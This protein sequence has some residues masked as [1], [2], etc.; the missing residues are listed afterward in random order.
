MVDPWDEAPI[1]AP[2]TAAPTL[3]QIVAPQR[4]APTGFR[5]NDAGDLEPIPG[6]PATK[7]DPPAGYRVSADGN[8]EFIPGGPADKTVTTDP[9]LQEAERTAA[10][11]ATRVLGGIK[12]IQAVTK[13]APSANK[14]GWIA[15]FAG[16]FGDE[17][18]NWANSPERRQ[19]EA[20][21][22][23]ILDAALT[24]GTGAAYTKEQLESYRQAYFPKLTDDK[25]TVEAKRTRLLRLLEAAKLKAGN[26]SPQID[27]A[28]KSLGGADQP[29]Q[30]LGPG[31]IGFNQAPAPENPLN[32]EQQA[33]YDAFNAANPKAT[34]AQLQAFGASIGVGIPNAE[35]IIEAR[36]KGAGVQPGSTAELGLTPEE[37]AQVDARVAGTS[38]AERIGAGMADTLT[39]GASDKIIAAG[40]GLAGNGDYDRELLMANAVTDQIADEHPWQYHGGQV[41]G[42]LI[43]PMF[44]ARTPAQLAK[45]GAAYGAAYGLGSSDTLAEVPGNVATGTVI[46]GGTG[47][48]GGKLVEKLGARSAAKAARPASESAER[49][50]RAAQFDID[51]P[52]GATSRTAAGVEKGLDILP[53]SAGRMQDARTALTGQ[54]ENAVETVASGHGPTTSFRGLGEA[55]QRGSNSWISKFEDVSSKAYDAIPISDKAAST[56]G[57]TRTALSEL[58]TI[59]ESNPK[60][61]EAFTN[62]RLNR[63]MEALDPANGGLSWKDLKAFRSRIG[64]EIGDQRFSESPT[65]TELRRLYGAL[66][67]DMRSTAMAQGP[68]ALRKFERANDLYRAGQ[69]RIEGA[70]TKILGDD[71]AKSPETAAARIQAL[72][73]EGKSSADL[74]LVHEVWKSLPAE[75]RGEVA[76]SLIRLA[77]QP[78]N[79]A[80]REFDPSVFVRSFK[81]MSPEAKNLIFG[82]VGKDLRTNL[83]EFV[84]VMGDLGANNALRNTSNTANAINMAGI[85]SVF[86]TAL[87]SF[88]VAAGIAGQTLGAYG[89]ARLW[90]NPK[91]VRWAT[92]YSK[93]LR[94]A[95]KAGTQPTKQGFVTQAKLLEKIAANDPGVAQDALGVRQMILS[96]VNENVPAKASADDGGPTAQ[97]SGGF[98]GLIAPGNIDL[99]ARPV[100]RNSDGSISTVRSMSFGTDKGEVLIPTVSDDGRIWSED[101]AV[102]NYR[103]TGRHL[104][105]FKTPADATTYAIDLHEQQARRYAR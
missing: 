68:Q 97:P 36:D 84:K 89:T 17:A 30:P 59:F 25:D 16:I 23:D 2:S 47:W 38:G 72:I 98:P 22:A 83:D 19:V 85:A 96:A 48:G 99:N 79:S 3:R 32:P 62:M 91:F 75:E 101:E 50:A 67:E 65:K 24:L 55:A 21:Q 11:L 103:R 52:M 76:N 13:D 33:A 42:G 64:E 46:G 34:V 5:Y 60:M 93:M 86:P 51:L 1:I 74:K 8:L 45:V 61:A 6:G 40:R 37:Q 92:G 88:P 78:A 53:G 102:A 29:K 35:A 20:A 7:S 95:A 80:G 105:I 9:K 28:I 44:E 73:R 18:H 31:D 100:V 41:A 49:V 90:T 54:V 77:G 71:A 15:S 70:L 10:F 43:L 56:L 94:G 57:E 4:E 26:A 69:Q 39:F 104:G 12:D 87:F 82:P 81:D 14:P 63:Y 27:E 58:T 66:S